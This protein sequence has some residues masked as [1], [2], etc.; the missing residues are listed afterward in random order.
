[1]LKQL[2]FYI[3]SYIVLTPFNKAYHY[4][5]CWLTGQKNNN[6]CAFCY[7]ICIFPLIQEQARGPQFEHWRKIEGLLM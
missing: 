5:L 4:I 3:D 7:A 1:M 6:H 2:I